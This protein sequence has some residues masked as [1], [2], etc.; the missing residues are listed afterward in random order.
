[1]TAALRTIGAALIAASVMGAIAALAGVDVIRVGRPHDALSNEL[2]VTADLLRHNLVV[3]LWPLALVAL[4]WP[5]I[6]GICHVGDALVAGQLLLHGATLGS[7]LAQQPTLWRFLPHLPLEWL[8][9]AVPAATWTLAR[10][11]ETVGQARLV[12]VAGAVAVA[13]ALAALIETYG[14]PL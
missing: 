3:A 14:A 9:L 6:P 2:A 7:A 11:G 12:G 1:V 10:R 4:R 5:S 13:L 8:A